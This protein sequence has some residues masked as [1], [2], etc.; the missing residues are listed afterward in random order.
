MIKLMICINNVSAVDQVGFQD[1]T[2]I[3][4]INKKKLYGVAQRWNSQAYNKINVH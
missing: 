3:A 1:R 4:Q 2:L